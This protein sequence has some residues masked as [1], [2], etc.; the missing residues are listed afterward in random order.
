MRI[1][2]EKM[3]I[4]EKIK[5]INFWKS[6]RYCFFVWIKS[7]FFVEQQRSY[8]T[9]ALYFKIEPTSWAFESIFSHKGAWAL[10][11]KSKITTDI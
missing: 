9:F 2:L 10:L 1:P 6:D 7:H 8:M 3:E 4:L 11:K 5:M